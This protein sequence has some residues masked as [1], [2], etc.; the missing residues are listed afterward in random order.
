MS[1][2]EVCEQAEPRTT[3][4]FDP[5]QGESLRELIV[6]DSQLRFNT[7]LAKI[8]MAESNVLNY[9][10]GRNRMSI[11][12]LNKLLAGTNLDVQCVIQLTIKTGNVVEDVDSTELEEMLYL[13][14]SDT[15]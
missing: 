4:R 2:I 1:F 7:Y 14:D 6:Q 15:Q 9:L 13:P 12:T 3:F 11:N 8:G 5:H 10:S